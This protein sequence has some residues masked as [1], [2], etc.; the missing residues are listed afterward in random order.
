MEK[1]FKYGKIVED[2]YFINRTQEIES[3]GKSLLSQINVILISPRRW[4]KSSLI[5]KISRK[6][7]K[8]NKKVKFCF[9][10][11]F[12]TRNE[13]EF[14]EYFATQVIKAGYS[15][16]EERIE[17]SKGF[18]KHLVPKFSFGLSPNEQFSIS[19]DW[20]SVKKA[21][22]EIL[23][24]PE[25]ISKSK[26]IQLIVCLDE[27]QNIAHY[28]DSLSFQK[29][30]R[31]SWQHHQHALYVLYGSKQHMMNELFESKSMPFY[32]FGEIY[33]L[34]KIPNKEWES[35]IS[36]KFKKTGKEISFECAS[37]IANTVENHPFFVQQLANSVWQHTEKECNIDIIN[38]ALYALLQQYDIIF[39]REID[40][41]TNLQLNL[42]K[43]IA[44]DEKNLTSSGVIKKYK[45]STSSAVVQAKKALVQKEI[46][47]E[48]HGKLSFL[49][50]LFKIWLREIYLK[51]E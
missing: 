11:L 31:A 30:L 42:L 22:E 50:P 21:P 10:D 6:L 33:F 51:S 47:E 27:F 28:G 25:R 15:K 26:G 46:I 8:Q 1:P 43:A 12:N 14:Y 23:Q 18:F 5:Q 13:E 38:E 32:K 48:S 45:L 41:I 7:E 20:E 34:D 40:L 35:Y 9:I 36:K 39:S 49:D 3:I 16:W 37:T 24:L 2:E 4:G 19:F 29:K 44:R 17:K